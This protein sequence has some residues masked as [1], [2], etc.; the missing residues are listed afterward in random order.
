MEVKY[1]TQFLSKLEDIFSESDYMLRYEKGNFNSGYCLLR[2]T[3]V[4]IVNKYYPLEGKVNSLIEILKQVELSTEKMTDKNKK[5]YQEI[6][7]S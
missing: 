6:Y 4:A 1:T 2:E 7:Q 3:H 5:L